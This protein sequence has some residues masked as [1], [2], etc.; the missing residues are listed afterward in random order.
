MFVAKFCRFNSRPVISAKVS[1]PSCAG[2]PKTATPHSAN[3]P[4]RSVR[5]AEKSANIKPPQSSALIRSI[6]SLAKSNK[7]LPVTSFCEISLGKCS[8]KK[9]LNSAYFRCMLIACLAKS[10]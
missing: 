1:G 9:F 2:A 8:K 4:C 3:A 6:I 5:V 7:S 10:A